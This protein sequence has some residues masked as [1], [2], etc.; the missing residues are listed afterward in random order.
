MLGINWTAQ[1]MMVFLW[2]TLDLTR[3]LVVRA[4]AGCGKSTT[5]V[6]GIRRYIDAAKQAGKRVRVLATSFAKLSVNDLATKL[7]PY[8][9]AGCEARSINSLGNSFCMSKCGKLDATTRK[10]DLAKAIEPNGTQD[11]IQA[12]A[13]LHTKA[14]ALAWDATCGKDLEELAEQFDLGPTED[15]MADGWTLAG[16]CEAAYEC[17]LL[18]A[19]KYHTYDFADQ[20]YLPLRNNWT[21]PLYDRVVIDETQDIDRAQ[22]ELVRRV[23]KDVRGICVVGDN[24]QAIYGFR[25]AD[26]NAIDRLK[27]AYDASE[28]GLSVTMRCAKMI[29]GYAR[30][31]FGDELADF[32]ANESNVEGTITN[33]LGI[34]DMLDGAKDGDFILSRT[35]APL[36]PLCLSLIRR[37]VRAFVAGRDVG[38]GLLNLIRKCKATSIEILSS[39][40]DTYTAKKADKIRADKRAQDPEW[41]DVKLSTVGDERDCIMACSEGC[42]TVQEVIGRIQALFVDSKDDAG[43]RIPGVMLATV[44]KAK[45][46]EAGT[47]WLCAGTFRTKSHDDKMVKYVAVTRAKHTLHFVKG[48]ETAG[49]ELDVDHGNVSTDP[50]IEA[51]RPMTESEHESTI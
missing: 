20:V 12:L 18:A 50:V 24:L 13:E 23:V 31:I 8:K 28:C 16:L 30:S 44:H 6:E 43:N 33:N 27:V 38:T 47:V 48:F 11:A 49:S 3:A 32:E 39:K 40:L 35:N 4:R 26:T 14:R 7:A 1:Q 10:Y 2:F 25:G 22:L 34:A 15:M 42:L 41:L 9:D 36:V 45:G 51:D 21:R 17:M 5:I 19:R 46:L 29:V 37:N